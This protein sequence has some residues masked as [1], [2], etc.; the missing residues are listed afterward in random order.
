MNDLT[1]Y[2]DHTN[3][4]PKAT[5]ADI[6]KLCSEAKRFGFA[7]VCVNGCYSALASKLL[8][9]SNVRTATVIGFP[10]GTMT[11]DA[12][13][14]EAKNAVVNGADE[15]DMVINLGW[16]KSGKHHWVKTEIGDIKKGI[17]KKVLKVILETCY[18]TDQEKQIACK[19]AVEAGA[20]YV[21][22]STGFGPAGATLEDVTLMITAVQGKALVKASGGIRDKTT[23]QKYIDLG[24]KR[25]G[26]SSGP[27]LLTS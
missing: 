21:K 12:K 13:V 2:I 27:Q 1:K 22:T 9:G 14:F 11:T 6:E 19:L 3:L 4:S 20:D 10:L 24:V 26:T 16:L 23:A 17:G 18:L 5:T 8:S 7:A 25:I 15:I